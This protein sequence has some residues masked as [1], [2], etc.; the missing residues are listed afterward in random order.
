[1]SA[2]AAPLPVYRDANFLCLALSR[3]LSAT[4][5]LMQSVAIGWQIYA[6]TGKVSYLGYVGLAQFLPFFLFILW[7]GQ[8]ADRQDR[9]KILIG[10]NIAYLIG[11]LS[12]FAYSLSGG[13][14]VGP[15]FAV[16]VLLGTSRAF[17]MPASQAL[18]RNVVDASQLDRALPIY[19]GL[20]HVA[21]VAGPLLGGFLYLAGAP[22]THLTVTLCLLSATV[23]LSFVKTRQVREPR[24]PVTWRNTLEGFRFVG[25]KPMLLGAIS[26]DLFAVLLGGATAM[27]PAVARDI[28]H[29]GPFAMGMLRAAPA[30]GSTLASL[31]LAR[32]PLR[33]HIGRWLFGGAALFGM[34][35]IAFGLSRSIWLSLG[36]LVLLGLGDMLGVYVRQYLIQSGTPDSVRG[37]VSAVSAVCIGASNELGEFES[38]VTAGWLGVSRS[39]VVGGVATLIVISAWMAR[40]PILRN[41]DR[42][43]APEK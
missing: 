25:A 33:R 17:A 20:F 8:V 24:M 1:M 11:S 30:V 23:M 18:L 5:I 38:G 10:C 37:R 3:F 2:T 13:R 9:R 12:L 27:L 4:A 40:F 35:T 16:L 41:M 22:V 43:P 31:Y 42:F 29:A 6:Q 32:Y 36:C 28:L 34:A 39:I 26:L 19:T 21:V 14:S 15:I 7:S